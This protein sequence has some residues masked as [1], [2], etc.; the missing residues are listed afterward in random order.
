M[1]ARSAHKGIVELDPALYRR[2]QDAVGAARVRDG[3]VNGLIHKA[4]S[5]SQ[6]RINWQPVNEALTVSGNPVRW[7]SGDFVMMGRARAGDWY[8][9]QPQSFGAMDIPIHADGPIYELRIRSAWGAADRAFADPPPAANF[10][11]R[12]FVYPDV[13]G[14]AGPMMIHGYHGA[15]ADYVWEATFSTAAVGYEGAWIAGATKGPGAYATKLV[16]DPA[17]IRGWP[18]WPPGVAKSGRLEVDAP[19]AVDGAQASPTTVLRCHL[20]IVASV[21]VDGD[22]LE[23]PT[24]VPLLRALSVQGFVGEAA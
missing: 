1:S 23:G 5:I 21:D 8:G 12:V 24:V 6:V 15:P 9:I 20:G 13:D 18:H 4:D 2:A 3:L 16:L 7:A 11:V 22:Q 14:S 17:V 10:T 19:N